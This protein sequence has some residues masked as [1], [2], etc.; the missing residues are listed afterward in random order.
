MKA[1]WISALKKDEAAVQ[2]VG[3]HFKKYGIEAQG[4]FWENDNAKMLWLGARDS[5]LDEQ[6]AV[7]IILGSREDL[8][9]EE[10]RYGLSMLALGVQA[11]RGIGFP[12][13]VMQTEGE[14]INIQELPTPL[15][16]AVVLP[17]EDPGTPAKLVA[18]VH[19][20]PPQLPSAYVLDMVGNEQLGQWLQVYPTG[21]AWPGVIFGVDEGEILFQAVG[22]CG[23]LPEKATLSYAM[24]G[25]KLEL[26]GTEFTAWATRNEISSENAYFIKIS[27][28]PKRLLFGPYAEDEEAEMFVI[29]LS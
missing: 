29:N 15:Q 16:R 5:L 12:V 14:P 22:P 9:N 4:H 25:I 26:G 27:G 28:S 1:I 23:Q 7:W 3:G 24:Q 6:I 2:K 13:V 20:K 11:R 19:A 18:K 8:E 17:A 21:E 10:L